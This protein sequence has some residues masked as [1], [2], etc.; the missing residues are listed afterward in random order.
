MATQSSTTVVFRGLVML[1]CLVAIPFA[2]LFGAS[3]PELVNRLRERRWDL[4]SLLETGSL[5]E[6]PPFRSTA[7]AANWNERTDSTPLGGELDAASRPGSAWAGEL[8]GAVSRDGG[9]GKSASIG[10]PAGSPGRVGTAAAGSPSTP[11]ATLGGPAPAGLPV[12]DLVHV[13]HPP[14]GDKEMPMGAPASPE[15]A[16]RKT[17]SAGSA[18]LL[19]SDEFQRIQRRLRQLG[20]TYYLLETWGGQAECYR[21]HARMAVG[22]S[23]DYV[24]HFEA[25]DTEALQAM[26]KVLS[27]VERWRVGR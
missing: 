16:P 20:A 22:G 15:S 3:L 23:P 19:A 14:H 1:V 9:L 2:A 25:T 4:S 12:S 17:P 7:Q 26:A 11:A 5:P 13:S 18:S 10:P 8:L 21:F 27:Q 6:A 24:R